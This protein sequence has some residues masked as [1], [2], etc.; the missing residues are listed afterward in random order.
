MESRRFANG[1]NQSWHWEGSIQ[2]QMARDGKVL[3]IEDDRGVAGVIQL[4]LEAANFEVVHVEDGAVGLNLARTEQFDVVL[5]DLN[6]PS[7]DGLSVCR[8]I[9]KS[10]NTPILMLTARQQV[11]DKVMGLETGADDYLGK[12]FDPMELMARVR[13]LHR[14]GTGASKVDNE[15]SCEV[16]DLHILPASRQLH[17]K[18]RPVHLT[19]KEFDLLLTLARRPSQVFSRRQLIDQCWGPNWLAEEKTVDVHLRRIRQKLKLV[20][21]HKFLEAV[22]SIGYRLVAP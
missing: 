4:S 1:G 13:A 7:L 2:A 16:G 14:R 8:E 12:P 15:E 3:V 19:P 22:H 21:D 18:G 10:A 17:I 6:L 9:R 5:L 11:F 20:S